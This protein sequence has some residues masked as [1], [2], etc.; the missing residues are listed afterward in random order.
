METDNNSYPAG[1][2]LECC[3][4]CNDLESVVYSCGCG[5]VICSMCWPSKA[6]MCVACSKGVCIM[7]CDAKFYTAHQTLKHSV[8][9]L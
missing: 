8:Y 2:S 6:A 5:A 9:C 3:N 7:C 4:V 1:D